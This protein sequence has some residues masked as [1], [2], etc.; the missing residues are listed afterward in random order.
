MLTSGVLKIL[1]NKGSWSDRDEFFRFAT[2]SGYEAAQ[3]NG[4]IF[5]HDPQESGRWVITPF[6]CDDFEL[7]IIPACVEMVRSDD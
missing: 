5:V 4:C 2:K 6:T 1:Q 7:E 3:W